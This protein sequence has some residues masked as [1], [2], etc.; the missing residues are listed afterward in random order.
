MDG[1][2]ILRDTLY[3]KLKNRR[4]SVRISAVVS[5]ITTALV[6]LYAIY[7]LSVILIIFCLLFGYMALKDLDFVK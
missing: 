7:S 3:L 4:K 1:G 2:R 6:L 5:L